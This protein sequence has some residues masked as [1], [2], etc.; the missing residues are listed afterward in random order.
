[1]RKGFTKRIEIAPKTKSV[2]TV[3]ACAE[4]DKLVVNDYRKGSD[5]L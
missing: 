5:L 2:I 4:I 3:D 1:M